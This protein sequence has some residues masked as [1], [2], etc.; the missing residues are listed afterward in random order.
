MPVYT[1]LIFYHFLNFYL[2]QI[3]NENTKKCLTAPR[4]YFTNCFI[5]SFNMN[6]KNELLNSCIN[7]FLYFYALCEPANN[8]YFSIKS[9][10]HFIFHENHY[11]LPF[12][13]NRNCLPKIETIGIIRRNALFQEK[14]FIRAKR[15]PKA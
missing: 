11:F 1:T 8:K 14:S 3:W 6:K 9:V 13:K 4:A 7:I 12:Q 10:F 15:R 5:N 2:N